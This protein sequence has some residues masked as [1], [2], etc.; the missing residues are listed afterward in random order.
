VIDLLYWRDIKKSVVV[1]ALKL[2]VLISLTMYSLVSVITFFSMAVLT[3]ALLY[4][5]GMTVMGAIQKSGT[6][7]PFK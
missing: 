7:N 3:V 4:R 6:E 1:L 2:T 5:V